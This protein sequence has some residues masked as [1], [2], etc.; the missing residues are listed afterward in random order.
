[1]HVLRFI[2]DATA[3]AIAIERVIEV[4]PRVLMT[5]LPGAPPFVEGVFSFRQAACIGIDLRRRLGHAPRRPMLDDHVLVVRGR[6]RIVGLVVDRVVGDS[7]LDAAVIEPPPPGTR[8]IAGVVP[9][10]DGV[11]LVQDVD[12]LLTDDE[13]RLIDESLAG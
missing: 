4:A 11:V 5:A 12:A 2:V 3:Y 6:T 10:S 9:L 1:M 13:E 7:V 8:H